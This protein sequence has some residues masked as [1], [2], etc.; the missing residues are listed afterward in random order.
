M[1]DAGVSALRYQ[2]FA[3]KAADAGRALVVVV[4]GNARGAGTQFRAFLPEALRR[5]LAI[6][7]PRFPS[8]AYAGYQTLSGAAGALSAMRAF[9]ATVEDARAA[10]GLDDAPVHLFG[11]SGGAQFAHRYA[12]L[13]P[14]RVARLTVA[15]A[16]WYTMLDDGWPFP[17]GV[18]PSAA[19]GAMAVQ[20]GAFLRM[21]IR[22]FAGEG[23]VERDRQLRTERWL[24]E[25]QG[26]HRLARALRWVDH[27]NI[28]A[29]SRGMPGPA[30]FE[31]LARTGHSF[32]EAVREADLV[33]RV[34]DFLVPESQGPEGS[35]PEIS[36]E[37]AS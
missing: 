12:L 25:H 8:Q 3:P 19:S 21:P 35:A 16:G 34:L 20:A 14:H 11:F 31:L 36:A 4:H 33:S 17:R 2:A 1:A 27:L 6:L 9:D 37:G 29:Q 23:D 10:L 5:D 13:A 22:V 7:A 32:S 28:E 18:A 15:A 24:D 30:S 26:E